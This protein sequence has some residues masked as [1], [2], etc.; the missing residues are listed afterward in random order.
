MKLKEQIIKELNKNEFPN[1]K[2]LYSDEVLDIFLEV[3]NDLL[4]IDKHNFNTLLLIEN[5]DLS[6]NSFEDDSLL[7]Y[8][9]SLLNHLDSINSSDKIRKIIEEFRPKLQDF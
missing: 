4:K 7:D 8:F 5:K 1:L 2:F 3:L 9:W 6:F